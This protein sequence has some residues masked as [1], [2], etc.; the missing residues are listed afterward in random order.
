MRSTQHGA[1]R[2]E[3]AVDRERG[4][5]L[6][7]RLAPGYDDLMPHD[8]A[9]FLVEEH[10]GNEPGVWDSSPPGAAAST[11]IGQAAGQLCEPP[12][13]PLRRAVARMDEVAGR[14]QALP[15]GGSLTVAWPA[16]L[17]FDPA[18][19]RRGRRSTAE[20]RRLARH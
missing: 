6:V 14:W 5:A 17:T 11:S 7:P 13:A 4:P 16:G 10:V 8:V 19:S 18:R 20:S 9:R 3:V 1:R 12:G 2:Y 15:R